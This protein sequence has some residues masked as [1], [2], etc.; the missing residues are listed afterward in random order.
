MPLHQSG[1]GEDSSIIK[2]ARIL[3]FFIIVLVITAFVMLLCCEYHGQDAG[4]CR[5]IDNAVAA[6]N[7]SE[8]DSER[9][10]IVQDTY[11]EIHEK[12]PEVVGYLSIPNTSV[13]Y[14]VFQSTDDE[15]Y[16]HHGRD[17]NRTYS[18][19]VYLD[20]RCDIADLKHHLIIYGHNMR[21]N[22]MF[23][24]LDKYK[25]ESF[26]RENPIITFNTVYDDHKWEIFSVRIVDVDQTSN[27]IIR[28]QFSS[29]KA[30]LQYIQNCQKESIYETP[31]VLSKD[32]VVLTLITCSYEYDNGRLL[33]QAKLVK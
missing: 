14:Y 9:E 2:L 19:E 33:V 16:L 15:Y 6:D 11:R 32:D 23:G 24:S 8:V 27:T 7:Q 13:L 12:Y 28:T 17:G 4:L 20:Y 21:N 29:D 10:R 18:G 3:G 25:K 5:G 31:V 1:N 26:Y 30:W 22:T